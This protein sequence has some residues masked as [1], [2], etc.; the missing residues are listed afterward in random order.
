MSNPLTLPSLEIRGYR[1]IRELKIERLGRANLI[2]GKNNVGKTSVLEA[3][4]LYGQPGSPR[5]IL[6][7]L[8]ARDET[9]D[10]KRGSLDD[11]QK[12]P[13]CL[14]QNAAFDGKTPPR[15][16]IGPVDRPRL[17]LEIKLETRE[18]PD[19]GRE[20]QAAGRVN[21]S[22]ESVAV[23]THLRFRMGGS[24]RLLR[25]DKLMRRF[26]QRRETS[27]FD[28]HGR[29]DSECPLVF[30]TSCG[31]DREQLA[32]LWDRIVQKPPVDEEM[33]AALEIFNT[34]I[35][36][37]VFVADQDSESRVPLVQL[38]GHRSLFPLRRLGDGVVRMFGLAVA[39]AASS[40]G[41]LLIDEIE[42]G[43][44]YSVQ[45]DLWRFLFKLATKL[46]VQIFATTHSWDMVKAFQLAAKEEAD[47]EGIVI[48][49]QRDGDAIR[50]TEFDEEEL[51]VATRKQIEVRG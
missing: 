17:D 28:M 14:F 19:T 30:V 50:V 25:I 37:V 23:H 16:T 35:S 4:R 20:E 43:I 46:N 5:D 36:R 48:R 9:V 42:N 26:R 10:V 1:G 12:P 11:V 38:R 32:A 34:S 40:D 15:I 21:A 44:H 29:L 22:G 51:E 33:L 13:L 31:I 18:V 49:L 41:F 7:I 39:L 27:Y 47:E 45:P 24:W 2:V 6:S 3:I 8:S